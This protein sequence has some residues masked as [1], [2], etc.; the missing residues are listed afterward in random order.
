[1]HGPLLPPI[2]GGNDE[3]DGRDDAN[4]R[5]QYVFLHHHVKFPQKYETN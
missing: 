3:P 4:T 2:D 5:C 1:M